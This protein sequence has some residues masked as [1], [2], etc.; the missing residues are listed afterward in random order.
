MNYEELEQERGRATK[1]AEWIREHAMA[2]ATKPDLAD[3]AL[4]EAADRILD[5]ARG[6]VLALQTA[7][8][9]LLGQIRRDGTS[10]REG[11]WGALRIIDRA[12]GLSRERTEA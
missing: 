1:L 6:D 4:D 11:A 5:V 9:W 12:L 8:G 10:R 7:G 2:E 3:T